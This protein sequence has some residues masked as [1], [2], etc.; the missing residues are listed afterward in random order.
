M[1]MLPPLAFRSLPSPEPCRQLSDLPRERRAIEGVARA[2][3]GDAN[4]YEVTSLLSMRS[5]HST[6]RRA[7]AIT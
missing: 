4:D 2:G 6:C 5:N 1:L 7:E 3:Q